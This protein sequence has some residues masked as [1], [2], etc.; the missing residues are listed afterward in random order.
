MTPPEN[1]QVHEWPGSIF[2][3]DENGIMCS[4]SRPAPLQTLEE[5][6]LQML[7][8]EKI[9]GGK[10]ICILSDSTNGNP[11]QSKEL[12]D[13]AAEVLPQF[14]KAIAVISNS[15]MGKMVANLF[16]AIKSQPYPIK[17]FDNENA[18]KEWLKQYL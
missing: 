8:F 4:I 11:V 6:K 13:Y 17:F 7:E 16:F 14:V 9:T 15:A 3:F 1:A 5:A 12:R 18:A 10:K 2:W